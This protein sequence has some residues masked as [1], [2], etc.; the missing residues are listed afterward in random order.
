MYSGTSRQ[1]KPPCDASASV[2][3]GLKCAPDIG[4][5][6]R[7]NATSMAPVAVVSARSAIATFPSASRSPMMPEPTT[8]ARR[9]AV[10][11]ASATARRTTTLLRGWLNSADKCAHEFVL[12]LRRD[13]VD[14]D[15]FAGQ[16]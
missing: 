16:E 11:S 2:T 15:A 13:R 6:V 5:K 14:I 12:H 3:A 1:G 4:P 9:K 7:I 10:P 8:A